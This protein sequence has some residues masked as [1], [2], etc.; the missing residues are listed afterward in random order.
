MFSK[1]MTFRSLKI[2]PKVKIQLSAIVAFRLTW[3]KLDFDLNQSLT[4]VPV[5][6]IH[7][8]LQ[9]AQAASV[10]FPTDVETLF[11]DLP[12]NPRVHS[13]EKHGT[14]GCVFAGQ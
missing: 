2:C 9:V 4:F 6:I 8:Q 3:I 5:K 14:L 13:I 12:W 10:T 7:I 1:E 11:A